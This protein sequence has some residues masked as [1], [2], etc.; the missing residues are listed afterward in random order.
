VAHD[1]APLCKSVEG[2]L[3]AY[4]EE[5]MWGSVEIGGMIGWQVIR[6]EMPELKTV[7][8]RR[9]LQDVYNSLIGL[10]FTANLTSLAE[11]DAI[12][13]LIAA[14]KNVYSIN[15]S[16]LDAPVMCKWLFEYCLELE[17]DFEW[18]HDLSN[19]NVQVN[20]DDVMAMKEDTDKRYALY[21]ADVLHR[22][23]G[24]RNCLH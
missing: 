12:L 11:Y 3:K 13:D 8:M 21:Q 7:V 10:G 1:V 2:F 4:R 9:P 19:L 17:F 22:M 6:Q 14:Q 23:E 24:I 16:D 15:S 5:G 20:M 18:W